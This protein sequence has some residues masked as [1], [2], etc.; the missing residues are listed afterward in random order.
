MWNRCVVS[1][2][3]D[4]A[5]REDEWANGSGSAGLFTPL[6]KEEPAEDLNA[7]RPPVEP[8]KL[9]SHIHVAPAGRLV[10]DL[11]PRAVSAARQHS[12]QTAQGEVKKRRP[13]AVPSDDRSAS[14][15]PARDRSRR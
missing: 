9:R 2:V 12:S 4:W 8:L 10:V 7:G 11:F 1:G 13:L 5:A 15:I 3:R 6:A 14:S